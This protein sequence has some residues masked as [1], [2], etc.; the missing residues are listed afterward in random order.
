MKKILLILLTCILCSSCGKK[1][2]VTCTSS[3]SDENL[4]TNIVIEIEYDKDNNVTK[5]TTKETIESDLKSTLTN[6]KEDLEELYKDYESLK[7]Y[8]MTIKINKKKLV[9]TEVIDYT[10]IDIDKY[11]ELNPTLENVLRDNK[12]YLDLLVSSYEASNST[13]KK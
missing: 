8:D 6:F 11:K 13:C 1:N 2:L 10:E 3:N 5:T 4:K 9:R 12:V 7:G